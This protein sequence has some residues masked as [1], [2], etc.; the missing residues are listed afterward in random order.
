MRRPIAAVIE[1]QGHLL[2][3][4][5]SNE[6]VRYSS[7]H[8]KLSSKLQT[9]RICR[10]SRAPHHR[11][12][13]ADRGSVRGGLRVIRYKYGAG[14]YRAACEYDGERGSDSKLYRRG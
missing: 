10:T 14:D 11:C 7:V 13:C 5:T 6:P 12:F 9:I 8:S 3:G 1:P 4:G 2:G